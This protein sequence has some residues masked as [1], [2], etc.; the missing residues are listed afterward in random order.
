VTFLQVCSVRLLGVAC[1]YRAS[2]SMN[3]VKI[4]AIVQIALAVVGIVLVFT[5][6]FADYY[7]RRLWYYSDSYPNYY[8]RTYGIWYNE[9]SSTWG[10]TSC[11]VVIF[12]ATA[13]AGFMWGW[14]S[15]G[16][17]AVKYAKLTLYLGIVEL[18]S[19]ILGGVLVASIAGS[20]DPLSWWFGT[21]SYSV[22][23][24]GILFIIIGFIAM[25]MLKP[26]TLPPPPPPPPP[27]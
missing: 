19:A 7:V 5:T 25:R 2:S 15:S 11:Y 13:I 14:M 17:T 16:Q 3:L 4:I 26:T 18:V 24:G 23:V 1:V 10:L 8:Y 27:S 22:L 9:D 12:V 21:A 6:E 20:Y